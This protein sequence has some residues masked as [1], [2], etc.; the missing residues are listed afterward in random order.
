LN[1]PFSIPVSFACHFTGV[2]DTA[3]FCVSFAAIIPLAALLGF[4]TEELALRVGHTLGGLLNATFGNTV[5]L[6]IAILALVKG[7]L[8]LVQ[9]AMIGSILSNCLLVLG[10]CFFAGGIRFHEQIYTI[11]S[12]QLNISLLGISA[13]VIVIPAAFNAAVTQL[14]SVPVTISDRDILKLSR[15]VA[16]ILLFLYAWVQHLIFP[17]SRRILY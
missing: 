7:E 17:T 11:R 1:C 9:A 4:A 6:I 12:A 14:G 3:T 16:F 10:C 2:S 13:L 8:R 15:G 5:E